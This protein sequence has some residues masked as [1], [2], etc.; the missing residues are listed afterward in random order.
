MHFS[1]E[2]RVCLPIF[3]KGNEEWPKAMLRELPAGQLNAKRAFG[4]DNHWENFGHLFLEQKQKKVENM[5]EKR[6]MGE[7]EGKSEK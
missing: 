7:R 1:F 2:M 4:W 6:R 3:T 5:L